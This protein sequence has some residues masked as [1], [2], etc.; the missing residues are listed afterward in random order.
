MRNELLTANERSVCE[1]DLL[2]HGH[3]ASRLLALPLVCGAAPVVSIAAA[4]ASSGVSPSA[5]RVGNRRLV[6]PTLRPRS[7]PPEQRGARRGADA[8]MVE[9]T[10]QRQNRF[11]GGELDEEGGLRGEN[12]INGDGHRFSADIDSRTCLLDG[13]LGPHPLWTRTSQPDFPALV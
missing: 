6:K 4:A 9:P 1:G 10:R 5:G 8:E 12:V 3:P 11:G 13:H 7:R 2:R